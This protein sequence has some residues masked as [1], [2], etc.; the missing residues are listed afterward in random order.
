MGQ[1]VG[2]GEGKSESKGRAVDT[3]QETRVDGDCHHE[4][5]I[6]LPSK[7]GFFFHLLMQGAR[8]Y[9]QNN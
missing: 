9:V 4:Q 3:K 1:G 6:G 2:G 5:D 8:G 7:W